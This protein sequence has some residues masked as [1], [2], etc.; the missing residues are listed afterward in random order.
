MKKIYS[1][2]FTLT[3]LMSVIA[4]ITILILAAIPTFIGARNRANAN[5]CQANLEIIYSSEKEWALD[6]PD[7]A[8]AGYI[9]LSTDVNPYID[10]GWSSLECPSGGTY[11]MPAIDATGDIPKPTC[12]EGGDHSI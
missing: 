6:N 11:A 4:I 3:E 1:K 12:S 2:G 5:A 8:V 7:V 10:D 9:I